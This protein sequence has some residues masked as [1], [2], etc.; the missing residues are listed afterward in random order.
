M[1][2]EKIS[3]IIALCIV[4]RTDDVAESDREQVLDEDFD[5]GHIAST[6]F[7][8]HQTH[9]KTCKNMVECSELQQR[10]AINATRS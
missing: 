6:Q 2:L 4:V 8:A 3:C 10:H 7:A 1:T 9:D 5:P